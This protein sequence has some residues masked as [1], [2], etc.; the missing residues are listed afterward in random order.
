M[1]IRTAI[2]T[3]TGMSPYS[4]SRYLD[5]KKPRDITHDEFEERV[6]KSRFSKNKKGIV[7]IPSQSIKLAMCEAAKMKPTSIP[8]KGKSTYT[9][10]LVRGLMFLH[11]I[12]TGVHIDKV[13][14]QALPVP[15]DGKRGGTTR[16]RK[17]FPF[18][19]DGWTASF[20]FLIVDDEIPND[21]IERA[22]DDAGKFIGIGRWRPQNFGT[23]GRFKLTKFEVVNGEVN[24]NDEE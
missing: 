12:P 22:I 8:G 23:Y 4:Q 2:A 16:V 18:I 6:W 13:E 19:P 15:S 14:R 17:I 10:N 24:N 5:E 9:K 21:V 1:G 3:I 11:D 7:V 20:S